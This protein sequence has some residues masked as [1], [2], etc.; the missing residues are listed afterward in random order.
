[1]IQTAFT[2]HLH[3]NPILAGKN[4]KDLSDRVTRALSA[5]GY[6]PLRGIEVAIHGRHV[7]LLGRVPSYF[8]KQIAQ[9]AALAVAGVEELANDLD[10]ASA[11]S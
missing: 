1:M 11:V 2:S 6:L 10:V 3:E 4:P 9:A 7:T 8:M 5:T